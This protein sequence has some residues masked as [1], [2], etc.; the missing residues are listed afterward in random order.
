[1]TSPDSAARAYI[2][3]YYTTGKLV[4]DLQQVL[5]DCG[6]W[7]E[8]DEELS[9]YI[10]EAM[11]APAPNAG[12]FD[13]SLIEDQLPPERLEEILD[14]DDPTE[15]EIKLWEQAYYDA[16]LRGHFSWYA[17]RVWC[18]DDDQGREMY[19]YS[20]HSDWGEL[21]GVGGPFRSV[22]SLAADLNATGK[23]RGL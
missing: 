14:G 1:M 13:V 20:L 22:A 17:V 4:I 3:Q 23:V 16:A 11:W 7:E 5:I 19:V 12:D 10:T 8:D 15:K 9:G 2:D 6:I 18:I 21:D